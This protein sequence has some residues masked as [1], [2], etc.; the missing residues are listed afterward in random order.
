MGLLFAAISSS[1]F[2][3]WQKVVGVRLKSDLNFS[4][5]ITWNRFPLLE[6]DYRDRLVTAGQDIVRTRRQTSKLSLAAMYESGRMPDVLVPA[7]A[8]LHEVMDPALGAGVRG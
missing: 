5:T 1:M 8:A 3:T 2:L 4:N 7:R 6:G